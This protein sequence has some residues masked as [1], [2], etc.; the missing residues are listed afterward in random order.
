MSDKLTN[1]IERSQNDAKQN[2]E[3]LVLA[4]LLAEDEEEN[5]ILVGEETS[6][7]EVESFDPS[8]IELSM[9]W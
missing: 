7:D 2:L 8:N 1:M 9:R 5:S 6:L 3:R 4:V